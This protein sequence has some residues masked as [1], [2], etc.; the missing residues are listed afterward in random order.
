MARTRP[1]HVAARV[2]R[3][4]GQEVVVRHRVEHA[5][6]DPLQGSG[7]AHLPARRVAARQIPQLA[8]LLDGTLAQDSD[9]PLL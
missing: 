1:R 3:R 8:T 4:M 7:A 6:L 2:G 5:A 9:T